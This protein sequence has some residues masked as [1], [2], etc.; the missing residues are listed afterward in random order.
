MASGPGQQHAE[1]ERMQI[2]LLVDP[3]PLVDQHAVHQRDLAG[4]AAEGEHAD[5][6]PN[7]ER[8]A[9]GWFG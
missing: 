9:E 3:F 2:A 8:L 5:L 4:R 6:R 1:I 7:V